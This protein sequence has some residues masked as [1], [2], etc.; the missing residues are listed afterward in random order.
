LVVADVAGKRRLVIRDDQHEYVF[1]EIPPGAMTG[2][3][4]VPAR[5][6]RSH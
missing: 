4:G 3:G 6:G 1:E 5:G 2:N